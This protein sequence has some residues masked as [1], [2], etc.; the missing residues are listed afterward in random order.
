MTPEAWKAVENVALYAYAAF[1][2]WL[3]FGRERRSR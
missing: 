3:M 1:V 2:V